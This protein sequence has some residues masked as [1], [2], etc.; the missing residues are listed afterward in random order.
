MLAHYPIISKIGAGGMGDAEKGAFWLFL[1]KMD[2]DLEPL[3]GDPR[4]QEIIKKFEP[5]Q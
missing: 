2:P 3:R 1:I 5:P 4:I